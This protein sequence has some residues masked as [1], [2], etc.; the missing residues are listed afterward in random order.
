MGF[1]CT[2]AVARKQTDETDEEYTHTCLSQTIEITREPQTLKYQDIG[3][4]GDRETCRTASTSCHVDIVKT[5]SCHS[6]QK[7]FKVD[8]PPS[9]TEPQTVTNHTL[10]LFSVPGNLLMLLRVRVTG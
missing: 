3:Y 1:G 2:R 8:R 7:L 9:H 4:R 10:T 6:E 5:G